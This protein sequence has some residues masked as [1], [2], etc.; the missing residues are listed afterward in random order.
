MLFALANDA[1]PREELPPGFVCDIILVTNTLSGVP[2]APT[3]F[4]RQTPE[5]LLYYLGDF[6]IKKFIPLRVTHPSADPDSE[7][8]PLSL[9]ALAL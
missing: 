1:S 7:S 5:L 8:R 3:K 6:K 9:T 4:C 2:K